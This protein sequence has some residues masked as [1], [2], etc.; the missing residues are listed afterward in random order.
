MPSLVA[1][2]AHLFAFLLQCRLPQDGKSLVIV[3]QLN[4]DSPRVDLETSIL[5]QVVFWKIKGG[6]SE[7]RKPVREERASQSMLSTKGGWE[8]WS[9][10]SIPLEEFLGVSVEHNAVGWVGSSVLGW[11]MLARSSKSQVLPSFYMMGKETSRGE[12]MSSDKEKEEGY[13]GDA[14]LKNI[15][16]F[17]YL[18][19]L[20]FISAVARGV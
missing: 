20:H 14:F 3:Y 7:A 8:R 4:S 6:E 13:R 1:S 12:R 16:L 5:L 2:F 15:Y 18:V 17:K 19:W 11:G 10:S 9:R